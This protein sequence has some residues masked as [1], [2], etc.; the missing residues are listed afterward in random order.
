MSGRVWLVLIFHSGV[1]KLFFVTEMHR[2]GECGCAGI[3]NVRHYRN[4]KFIRIGPLSLRRGAG[5]RLYTNCTKRSYRTNYYIANY[6]LPI[7]I[8]IGIPMEHVKGSSCQK[9]LMFVIA[10]IKSLFG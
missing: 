8:A 7:P 9:F 2:S 6:F 5:V 4:K 1:C 10:E 3:L